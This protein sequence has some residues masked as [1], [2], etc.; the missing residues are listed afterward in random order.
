MT[1][2]KYQQGDVIIKS[3]PLKLRRFNKAAQLDHLILQQS[4]VTGHVHQ[5]SKGEAT[6]FKA[7][8]KGE[9]YLIISSP[10][11]IVS[12]DEHKDLIIPKGYYH[13]YGVREFD[14]IEELSRRIVD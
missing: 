4:K 13:V 9:Y 11:A 3:I 12:H 14:P 1:I 5:I 10:I 7:A 6:L 2:K 8:T